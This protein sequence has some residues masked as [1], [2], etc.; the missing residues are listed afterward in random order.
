MTK[1]SD[2]NHSKQNSTIRR[3][4]PKLQINAVFAFMICRMNITIPLAILSWWILI[5][6]P[7]I[8]YGRR[9]EFLHRN[10]NSATKC[11]VISSLVYT[12]LR[13]KQ[14]SNE[15]GKRA[16]KRKQ[17]VLSTTADD[18]SKHGTYNL[19]C[20]PSWARILLTFQLMEAYN[21]HK[22]VWLLKLPPSGL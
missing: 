4:L 12:E 22:G 7:G 14:G 3:F 11:M 20:A 5:P 18:C 10:N 6:L 8:Q 17:F 15:G 9:V 2:L 19:C 1:A 16:T 21:A 13:K